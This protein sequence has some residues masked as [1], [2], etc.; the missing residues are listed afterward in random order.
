MSGEHT[1]ILSLDGS[2]ATA[3]LAFL[4][5]AAK[6]SPEFGDRLIDLLE[7]G[8]ELFSLNGDGAIACAA[9]ELLVRF[10][11]SDAL[12]ILMATFGA[13]DSNFL[14]FEHHSAPI[15]VREFSTTIGN[16]Q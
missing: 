1:L 14:V 9:R 12:A 3:W 15:A 11:P 8:Q 16:Y 10:N 2:S 13:G 5:E 4:S 6:V 7:S